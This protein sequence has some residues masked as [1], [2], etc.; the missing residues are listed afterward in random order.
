MSFTRR[1]PHVCPG[2]LEAPT[3][4]RRVLQDFAGGFGLVA[5][6]GLLDDERRGARADEAAAVRTHFP[7]KAKNVI[8]CFMDG[9]VSHVDSFD[10]KPKLDELDGKAYADSKNPTARGDRLWLK[11]PWKFAKHGASGLPVSSLFPY[12]A[13]CADDLAVIRSMKAD[14]PLHSTGV[15][16]LHTG[17]NFA[18]RPSLGSWVSYGLG[19]ENRNLPN[20]VVLSFGVVPCGG[21]ET[22][23]SAFL[24]IT[25]QASQFRIEGAPVDNIRPGNDDRRI[26]EAKL[27]WAQRQNKAFADRSG[28]ERA[29]EAAI[30]NYELAYRMQSLVPDI[31]DLSR[32]TRETQALYGIDSKIAS[33]RQY[34]IQCLR[35]RRLIESGVRFVEITCPPGAS[36]GTWDQHGGLKKG[37]EKNA[38]DTDQ[39]IAALLKDLKRRGLLEETL[40]VWAGEF[41]RTP[42]SAGRDGRDHHPEGFSIWM[43]GGG[44]KPGTVY[45]ATDELGMQAVENVTTI[46]DLHATILHLLG[47]DHWKLTFRFGGRDMRLTDVHGHVVTEILA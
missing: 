46:H 23:S 31:V 4:R 42:H 9:G 15:L 28:D 30:G 18:G 7:A 33:Q 24:P 47:L 22:F 13:T 14:L 41:G 17:A 20:F 29:I 26:Q 34:G 1:T 43:A 8:F 40:V 21:L 36:N 16:H 27:A 12:L 10:P 2:R 6:A 44:V 5:L 35:A 19:S 11:S 45:G 25:N 3:S 38:L 32:E 37:H 39:A